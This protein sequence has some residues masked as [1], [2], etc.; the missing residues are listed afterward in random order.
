MSTQARFFFDSLEAAAEGLIVVLLDARQ[1]TAEYRF[2]GLSAKQLLAS[3]L[4]LDG[5]IADVSLKLDQVPGAIQT[6]A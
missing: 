6:G 4:L 3:G 1:T 5:D 2:G